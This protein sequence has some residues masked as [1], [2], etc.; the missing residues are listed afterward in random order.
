MTDLETRPAVDDVRPHPATRSRPGTR[1]RAATASRPTARRT[2]RPRPRK[3]LLSVHVMASVALLGISAAQLALAIAAVTGDAEAASTVYRLMLAVVHAVTIPLAVLT[4]A[5]SIA[6]GRLTKWGLFEYW[7][8]IAKSVLFVGAVVAAVTL[9]RPALSG[10]AGSP[11]P[12]IVLPLQVV[13]FGAATVLS[14][15]KPWGRRRR[16]M[17]S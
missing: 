3:V 2:L 13:A 17:E 10:G 6:L 1:S 16:T 4:L 11:V 15:F 12:L 14:V 7:W 5:S 9:L 8:V